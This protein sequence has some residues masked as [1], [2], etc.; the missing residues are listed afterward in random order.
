VGRDWFSDAAGAAVVEVVGASVLEVVL[1]LVLV[2]RGMVPI[3]DAVVADA[4]A[5]WD[6]AEPPPSADEHATM[7]NASA[8]PAAIR[9][10]GRLSI[11]IT[12]FD[13]ARS[14]IVPHFFPRGRQILKFGG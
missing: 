3:V 12:A 8:I 5:D 14:D 9:P 2:A 13:S 7:L 1:L 10:L 6:L 11:L 4:D